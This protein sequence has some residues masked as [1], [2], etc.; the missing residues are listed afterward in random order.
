MSEEIKESVKEY[1]GKVLKSNEDL[2]TN[3]CVQQGHVNKEV[4]I[5][6]KLC[7]EAVLSR[8]EILLIV[9]KKIQA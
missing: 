3:A 7:H 2:K 6:L 4:K 8:F 1:Y 9:F 5:A